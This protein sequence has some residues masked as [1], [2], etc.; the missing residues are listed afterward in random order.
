M[1]AV[2]FTLCKE[3]QRINCNPNP[4]DKWK[5]SVSTILLLL[6]RLQGKQELK[7][8]VSFT[9][10][11][12]STCLHTNDLLHALGTILKLNIYIIKT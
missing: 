10:S 1:N 4:G 12:N 6:M 3:I 9:N 2:Q 7:S 5:V 11:I 8:V